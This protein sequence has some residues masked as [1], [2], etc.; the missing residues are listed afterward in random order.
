METVLGHSLERGGCLQQ[1]MIEGRLDLCPVYRR[2]TVPGVDLFTLAEV[3]NRLMLSAD[4]PRAGRESVLLR[5][6]ES[7]AASLLNVPPSMERAVNMMRRPSGL[8]RGSDGA[9][10]MP[11]PSGPGRTGMG[12]S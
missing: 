10:A 11:K 4:H 8:N 5:E 9:A 1:Q 3:R 2:Q 6:V 7:E 12:Y